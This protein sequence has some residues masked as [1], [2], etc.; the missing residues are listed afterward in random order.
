LNKNFSKELNKNITSSIGELKKDQGDL[1][2][3]LK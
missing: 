2:W 3:L 1:K